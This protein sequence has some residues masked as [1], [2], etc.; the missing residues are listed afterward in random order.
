ME[1]QAD[2]LPGLGVC[3][4]MKNLFGVLVIAAI[5]GG[6]ATGVFLH[7]H[8][9]DTAAR[10][11]AA[12]NFELATDLFLRLI[13]MIIAPLVL[14]T[15]VAGLAH[16]EGVKEI[17]RVG[18]K[19]MAWFITA[20]ILSLLI[21]LV[22][23]EA[24]Q[25]GA[26][27]HLAA[28]ASAAAAAAPPMKFADI[29]IH[30]VPSSIADA[31]ARNEILQIVVFALALGTAVASLGERGRPLAALAESGGAA[32]LKVTGYVM[33][34]APIAIF[35]ALAAT[36]TTRGPDILGG[37]ARLIGGYYLAL[38][39]LWAVLLA[40]TFAVI[41]ARTPKFIRAIFEAILLALSTA[42][43]E[44]AF[45]KLMGGLEGFGASRRIVGFVLPIG[46]SFNLD[47]SMM[48]CV[49]AVMFIAQ[50]YGVHLGTAQTFALMAMLLV[51]SKGIA[52]VPRAALVVVS[53][54]LDYFRL[55]QAGLLMILA[56]DHIMDMGR[57]ATNVFGNAIAATAIA[58]W[59]GALL[60]S[61]DR[62]WSE[63][64]NARPPAVVQE[65][66]NKEKGPNLAA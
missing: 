61:S 65:A 25:P 2:P 17:G 11:A 33:K 59:E 38:V 24:L 29:L 16:M 31:M 45:P 48:Y 40:I 62:A 55:P 66:R 6:V 56:V 52:G 51:T 3:P 8:L 1:T 43:S 5:V 26:G 10:E 37:Y 41:G 54:N 20:S 44:A 22:A 34:L 58:K 57:S 64:E 49:F 4:R 39:A 50:A 47:G 27:L 60:P 15:L 21:G 46:Y 53:A 28:P 7:L 14:S 63:E 18:A 19:T 30:A 13:R 42:S 32:M 9:P 35:C 36:L 23:V 12:A